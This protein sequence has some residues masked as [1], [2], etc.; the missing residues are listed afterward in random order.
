MNEIRT[1]ITRILVDRL[2]IDEDGL[3]DNVKF[4]YDLGVD[5]LDFYEVIV[6]IEKAFNITIPDED[7]ERLDTL[8]A[9]VA[10]IEKKATHQNL[11]QVA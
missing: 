10:Y 7:A 8:G 4:Y 3:Q 6:D 5:S 11:R 9:L 2:A 1:K